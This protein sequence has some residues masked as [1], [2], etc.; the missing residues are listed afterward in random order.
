M[1]VSDRETGKTLQEIADALA[2]EAIPVELTGDPSLRVRR[3]VPPGA[4]E[5]AHDLAI[6]I[7]P[8][9]VAALAACRAGAAMLAA[10]ASAPPGGPANQLRVGLP[11]YALAALLRLFEPPLHAAPG[12]HPSAVVDPTARLGADVSVGPSATVGPGA[13]IGDGT[14]VMAQVSIGAGA[15]IGRGC[16]LHP[17]VRIGE[18]VVLGDRCILQHNASLGAD[19]FGY[20]TPEIGAAAKSGEHAPAPRRAIMRIASLG[21]VVLG[22]DVEVGAGSTID[23]ATLGA[24]RI[25][26]GTK[27]DNLV[28]IGHNTAVGEDCLICGLVGISG[29]CRIGNRVVLAGGVGVADHT[30]LGDDAVVM[31]G[32]GVGQDLSAGAVVLGYPAVP[33]E[34][35]MEQQTYV[36]R[37]KRMF[38]DMI[39]LQRRVRD[40]ESELK[41][42][43]GTS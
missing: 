10:G 25:G 19:G 2:A 11:R 30:T 5:G 26:R 7:E 13:S 34:R 24:T 33:R 18:R 16:L 38:N 12:V 35:F 23:R 28:M 21:T 14:I 36:R 17:G 37:L 32:S 15:R 4:A 40:L 39:E 22:D 42:R 3:P 20:A 6:A 27:I 43:G 8:K 29:S 31:A 1:A 9:A 41:T